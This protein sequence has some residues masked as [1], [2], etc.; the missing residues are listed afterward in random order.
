MEIAEFA[1]PHPED[2]RQLTLGVILFLCRCV[3]KKRT[4]ET[5]HPLVHRNRDTAVSD[6]SAGG[7][8]D[9]S[10][11][12]SA[13]V[14]IKSI[15]SFFMSFDGAIIDAYPDTVSDEV[16]ISLCYPWLRREAAESR[17]VKL[18]VRSMRARRRTLR[19]LSCASTSLRAKDQRALRIL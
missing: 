12:C 15:P 16:P 5:S 7:V 10:R 13:C 17:S 8:R 9:R 19:S 14:G 3:R 11:I 18:R 1:P 2:E 4:T 6:F